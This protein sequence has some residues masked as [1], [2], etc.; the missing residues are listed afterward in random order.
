MRPVMILIPIFLPLAGGA[1]LLMRHHMEEM[2]RRI[3]LELISLATTAFVWGLLLMGRTPVFTLYRFTGGFSM[4]FA[5]DGMSMLFAG[6]VSVMWPL[7]FLYAFAYMENAGWKNS[8]FAFYL[9]TYGITLGVAFSA[10]LLTMYVF[11][12]MLTLVT[13]PLVAHYRDHEGMHAARTY[14][15]YTIGGAALAF[16]A[17]IWI[18][19]NGN[20]GIFSYGGSMEGSFAGSASSLVRLIYLLAFFGFGVK[21]AVFPLHAWLPIAGVAPTPVTALLHAVAVVNSGAFAVSR[22]TWY[23]VGT[24]LIKGTWAQHIPL[25]VSSFTLVFA[26]CMAVKERHFKRRLAYSTVSNLS[27]ML[28]GI[29][30][31]TVPGLVGGLS[32]ML[33]HGIIK[34]VLFLCAG[35]FMHMTGNSYIYE[36]NGAG[37]KMPVNFALY[38]LSALSLV[39]IPLFAG[40]VSK[41]QLLTAGLEAGTR[42]GT[43]G[44]FC[45]ITSAFLCAVYTLSVTIRAYFPPVRKDLYRDADVKEAPLLMLI[46]IGIFAVLNVAF[47]VYPGPVMSFLGRIAQGLL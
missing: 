42:L 7:V 43:V 10:S 35:A 47:G 18:T 9:M 3:Y 16:M 19:L 26:A 12:E 23:S 32:H 24:D 37:R 20:E 17:V 5:V 44:V 46:P 11:Y 29:T 30:L 14:A 45:L 22:L 27:Y 2:H 6:M 25:A 38:T 21:A 8:F 31:M 40:F 34:M 33:F 28:F 1:V 13:I 36:V 39:G 41:W 4:N 15:A